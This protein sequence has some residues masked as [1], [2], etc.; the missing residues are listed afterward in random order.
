[1]QVCCIQSKVVSRDYTNHTFVYGVVCAFCMFYSCMYVFV[2]SQ[3]HDVGN[4]VVCLVQVNINH[5]FLTN[6]CENSML[7]CFP[8]HFC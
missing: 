5:Y 2:C 8:S 4:C 1:M 6:F 7:N 3:E